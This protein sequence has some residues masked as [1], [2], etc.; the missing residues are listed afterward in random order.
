MENFPKQLL[1]AGAALLG[2]LA[3]IRT[4]VCCALI[5][6]AIDFLAGI[7]ADRKRAHRKGEP[8]RFESVKAWKTIRKAVFIC[9]GI[10]LTW[11]LDDHILAFAELRLAN[12]FTG[13]VCGVELWSYLENAAI[14]S[15]HSAFRLFRKEIKEH[16]R[17]KLE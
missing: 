6:V 8:W 13:F 3:P 11:L 16:I 7:A 5:F 1:G 12:L 2:L 17:K 10:V 14:I 4:L 9:G 15:D